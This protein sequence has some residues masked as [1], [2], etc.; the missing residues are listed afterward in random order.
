MFTDT[1]E[2]YFTMTRGTYAL[3][4]FRSTLLADSAAVT[5]EDIF[6]AGEHLCMSPDQRNRRI[7]TPPI[8]VPLP[9]EKRSQIRR[10]AWSEWQGYE[11]NYNHTIMLD[12]DQNQ[13]DVGNRAD[14]SELIGVVIGPPPPVEAK[15]LYVDPSRIEFGRINRNVIA[16]WSNEPGTYNLFKILRPFIWPTALREKI[17]KHRKT[18]AEFIS[19]M[20][21][22]LLHLADRLSFTSDKVSLMIKF[23]RIILNNTTEI[24][25]RNRALTHCNFDEH[26]L[27]EGLNTYFLSNEGAVMYTPVLTVLNGDIPKML[28]QKNRRDLIMWRNRPYYKQVWYDFRFRDRKLP[29]FDCT[30]SYCPKKKLVEYRETVAEEGRLFVHYP[31]EPWDMIAS[32]SMYNAANVEDAFKRDR[33]LGNFLIEH[34]KVS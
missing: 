31:K 30:I 10:T 29:K 13:P 19:T 2:T 27:L 3:N 28:A 24:A 15:S 1:Q 18:R 25:R 26:S 11:Y 12:G 23:G 34:L 17:S 6:R 33:D 7:Y 8:K 14:G 16:D 4:L 22:G 21:E 20:N 5:Y 9:L 32:A